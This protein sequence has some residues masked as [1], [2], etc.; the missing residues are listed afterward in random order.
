MRVLRARLYEAERERQAAEQAAARLRAGRDRARARRRSA[1]TTSRRTASPTIASAW[2]GGCRTCSPAGSTPFTEALTADEQRRVARGRVNARRGSPR[3]RGV[4]RAQ[5]RRL[6]AA[7]RR[8]AALARARPLAGRAVHPA[9][10]AA[11]RGRARGGARARRAARRAASRSPTCSASGGSGGSRCE[12]TRARSCRGPRRR[13]SSSAPSRS[14]RTSSRPASSTSARAA[15]RSRSRSPTSDPTPA[16]S[17]PTSRPTRSRS[18]ARTPRALGLGVEL[19]RERA[20]STA[21]RGPF[22]LVVS[23]PPYVAADGARGV[24]SPRCATGS[25]GSRVV[26]DGQ[27][28]RARPAAPGVSSRRAA[29]IVLECHEQRG[30]PGRCAARSGSAIGRGRDRHATSRGASGWSRHGGE[31]ET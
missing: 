12:R 27:T 23:N 20:C 2:T 15:A 11:D 10:P 3:G 28:E 16:S 31:P 24:C 4:P 6:A 22:D 14:S 25:R 8:A 17:R 19:R 13:S 18:P 1:P 29:R 7:R 21:S 9:R 30:A 5:G 26:D